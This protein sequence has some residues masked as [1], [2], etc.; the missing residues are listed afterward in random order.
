[1]YGN[2][3]PSLPVA[4]TAGVE[5]IND[6]RVELSAF[7][8]ESDELTELAEIEHGGKRI[9]SGLR[10]RANL[11]IQGLGVRELQLLG[12]VAVPSGFRPDTDGNI[13]PVDLLR[14]EGEPAVVFGST[15]EIRLVEKPSTELSNKPMNLVVTVGN[16]PIVS[17]P[18]VAVFLSPSKMSITFPVR[19]A[20]KM[21]GYLDPAQPCLIHDDIIV[22]RW[23]GGEY[24]RL[25]LVFG[26]RLFILDHKHYVDRCRFSREHMGVVCYTHFRVSVYSE[27]IELGQAFLEK[28]PMCITSRGR[29]GLIDRFAEDDEYGLNYLESVLG[30]N[31]GLKEFH[32]WAI[33][34]FCAL[35]VGLKGYHVY[36]KALPKSSYKEFDSVIVDN[37]NNSSMSSNASEG[38][39]SDKDRFSEMST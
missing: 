13:N 30:N 3:P 1:M 5:P 2:P 36:F 34:A 27:K 7:V 16:T 35:L 37:Q 17:N 24:Q 4:Y 25:E 11:T 8:F 9:G 19:V 29:Y 10:V 23:S 6:T 15:R 38:D 21:V 28:Y 32:T 26:N 12:L 14:G 18:A 39:E 20:E 22:C 31:W 33:A